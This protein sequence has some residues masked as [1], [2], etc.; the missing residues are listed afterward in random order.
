[1]EPNVIEIV[2][3]GNKNVNWLKKSSEETILV[4]FIDE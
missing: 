1:V 3:D 2:M 4:W